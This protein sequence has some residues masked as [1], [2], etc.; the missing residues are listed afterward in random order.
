MSPWHHRT[1]T[2][3]PVVLFLFLS[4]F[5]GA[6]AWSGP[7]LPRPVALSGSVA[8][9]A[10]LGPLSLRIGRMPLHLRRANVTAASVRREWVDRLEA[11]GFTIVAAPVADDAVATLELAVILGE[12]ATMPDAI[13]CFQKLE[14]VQPARFDRLDRSIRVPTYVSPTATMEPRASVVAAV[15]RNLDKLIEDFI[16]D[17]RRADAELEAR[18]P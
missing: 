8:S 13:L 15:K 1:S 14:L 6:L 10:R 12:D 11:A 18:T 5:V 4:L 2:G 16:R 9:L 3:A 17:A 7:M